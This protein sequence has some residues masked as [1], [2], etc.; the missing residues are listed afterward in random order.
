MKSG[1]TCSTESARMEVRNAYEITVGNLEWN[2]PLSKAWRRWK[3]NLK[4]NFKRVWTGFN[5]LSIGSCEHGAEYSSS[6][7]SWIFGNSSASDVIMSSFIVPFAH[8]GQCWHSTWQLTSVASKKFTIIIFVRN[9][10]AL[11]LPAD[12]KRSFYWRI[13]KPLWQFSNSDQQISNFRLH[14][15]R[16]WQ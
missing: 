6:Q 4:I 16:S 3:D 8:T 14:T 7:N 12:S 11:S 15:V 1:M 10:T 2:R 13:I 5:W 9:T